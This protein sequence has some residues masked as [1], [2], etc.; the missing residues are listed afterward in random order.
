[1]AKP[2]KK[3]PAGKTNLP[4]LRT[5]FPSPEEKADMRAACAPKKGEVYIS[6]GNH[7]V[8]PDI[9]GIIEKVFRFEE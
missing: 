7:A 8:M 2:S 5:A 4:A 3:N 6:I 1:M 9:I